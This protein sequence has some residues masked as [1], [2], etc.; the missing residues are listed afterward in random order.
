MVSMV[1]VARKKVIRAQV[2]AWRR[3][4]CVTTLG[5]SHD[6]EENGGFAMAAE[7]TMNVDGVDGSRGFEMRVVVVV[8]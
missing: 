3:C 6:E 8:A 1:D 2:Q 7:F 4:V 5:F